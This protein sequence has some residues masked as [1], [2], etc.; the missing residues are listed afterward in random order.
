MKKS[1]LLLSVLLLTALQLF[2]QATD[3]CSSAPTITLD[4]PSQCANTSTFTATGDPT[5][6]CSAANNTAWV[7]Y[8]QLTTGLVEF[9]VTTTATTT[10][11]TASGGFWIVVYSGT[12]CPV[13][14]ATA[15]GCLRGSTGV[16][17]NVANSY[18][19]LAAGTYYLMIDG[20]SNDNGAFCVEANTPPPP[21]ANDQC[22]GATT[23]TLG[24]PLPNQFGATATNTGDPTTVPSCFGETTPA[25]NAPVWYKFVA[26]STSMD[27]ST[28]CSPNAGYDTQ[29]QLYSGTCASLTPVAGACN[30]DINGAALNMGGDYRSALTATGLT[31]GTTYYVMVDGFGGAP[32]ADFCITASATPTTCNSTIPSFTPA[33]ITVASG[34]AFSVPMPAGTTEGSLS[35]IDMFVVL[36]VNNNFSTLAAQGFTTLKAAWEATALPYAANF[37]ATYNSGTN[38]LNVPAGNLGICG[39]TATTLT[40]YIGTY[41]DPVAGFTMNAACSYYPITITITPNP[42]VAA[43]TPSSATLGATLTASGGVAYSWSNAATTA[44]I[45]PTTAGTYT[46]TVTNNVGCTATATAT[47]TSGGSAPSVTISNIVNAVCNTGGS[48]KA[49]PSGGVTPYTALWSNGATTATISNLA[50]GT[51]TVTVTGGN[52][53]TATASATITNSAI[54]VPTGLT[55]TNITGTTVT[56]NWG[57]VAGAANYSI[58]GRKVGSAT[59]TNVGPVTGT[60]KNIQSQIA[61]GKTYEW[62]V[63]ANCAD[64]IT[65]SAFSP[66]VTFTTSPCVNKTDSELSAEWDGGFKTFSLSP[67]PANNLVTVFYSTETQTPLNISIIDV[68][69]RVVAQQNTLATQGDNT[70][71]LDTNQLPQGY[72]VVE[73]NDG[74]TKMHEKLLIAR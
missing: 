67:N 36:D 38:T 34:A 11:G 41:T 32:P 12:T 58:Q 71:N 46:V 24:T 21:P 16:S 56:L 3:V 5:P 42:V 64:G 61:C 54:A 40:A 26:S 18:A 14:T 69:G 48:M 49:N 66:T 10:T 57:A 55:T 62:K 13:S 60:S 6:P 19:T 2:G 70:I 8:T 28:A 44:A 17:G 9:R 39:T 30:D 1:F 4:G 72:Y 68:T 22:S 7:K 27:V 63:R 37:G 25:A 73:L 43:V 20:F 59:W 29:I 52:G 51:Y 47:I 31:V 50:A 45:T 65:S 53:L 15:L 35:T 74:T 33:A 23:L